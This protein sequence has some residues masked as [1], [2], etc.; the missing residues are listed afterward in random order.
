MRFMSRSDMLSVGLLLQSQLLNWFRTGD[1]TIDAILASVIFS[2][3]TLA[4]SHYRTIVDNL[5]CRLT[6]RKCTMHVPSTLMKGQDS[7]SNFRYTDLTW[8]LSERVDL[9]NTRE[10]KAYSLGTVEKFMKKKTLSF[11]N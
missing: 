11:C 9:R 4:A 1:P 5:K 7:Y 2:L 6:L 10:I 3:M 8:F